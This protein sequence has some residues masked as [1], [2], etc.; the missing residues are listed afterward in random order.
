MRRRSHGCSVLSQ[1]RWR[2]AGAVIVG[3]GPAGC[4]TAIALAR[5]GMR[6]ITVIEESASTEDFD[7]TK[8]FTFVLSPSGKHALKQL[9]I[10]GYNSIGRTMGRLA[11]RAVTPAGDDVSADGGMGG[12]P[13]EAPALPDA[14]ADLCPTMCQR[15]S[16]NR[17]LEQHIEVHCADS[18]KVR[19]SRCSRRFSD[20]SAFRS[21][22]LWS[23]SVNVVFNVWPAN[24]ASCMPVPA[25]A[26]C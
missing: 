26:C 11:G 9:G 16:L 14:Q 18:V 5:Q 7:P 24:G 20:V 13:T 15:Q 8:A 12:G 2:C 23:C 6:N 19:S 17:I 3:G 1:P 10:Q 25:A 22:P 21:Q 4:A